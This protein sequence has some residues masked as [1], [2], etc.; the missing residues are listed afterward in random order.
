MDE[1]N[2]P[3][4]DCQKQNML[5]QKRC[6]YFCDNF[7]IEKNKMPLKFQNQINVVLKRQI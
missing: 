2:D 1:I 4:R 6:R 5:R 7:E 3:N